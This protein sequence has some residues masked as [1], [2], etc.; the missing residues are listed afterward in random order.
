MGRGLTV[1]SGIWREL[2]GAGV[3][4]P[5]P[6]CTN[7]QA[8]A[9]P[10]SADRLG[11]R[12][13]VD[14]ELEQLVAVDQ[15]HRD[16][17]PVLELERVIAVDVDLLVGERRALALCEDHLP[18]LVAQTASRARVHPDG[19]GHGPDATSADPRSHAQR[20]HSSFTGAGDT[21]TSTMEDADLLDLELHRRGGAG[22]R[23]AVGGRLRP[24]G[25]GGRGAAL[26]GPRPNTVGP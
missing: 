25:R 3:A 10:T 12:P 4:G 24:H 9:G 15:D 20:A 5:R 6:G 1:A 14:V 8:L 7:A 23:A 19:R 11:E 2:T 22:G 13:T 18:G 17:D 16:P 26:P 21:T